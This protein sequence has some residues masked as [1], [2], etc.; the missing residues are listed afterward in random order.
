MNKSNDRKPPRPKYPSLIVFGI[1]V[2]LNLIFFQNCTPGGSL[3][4]GVTGGQT[5]GDAGSLGGSGDPLVAGPNNASPNGSGNGQGYDG[6]GLVYINLGIKPCPDQ[7]FIKSSMLV[8]SGTARLIRANCVD[9]P[10]EGTDITAETKAENPSDQVLVYQEEKFVVSK[11]DFT[12]AKHPEWNCKRSVLRVILAANFKKTTTTAQ[13]SFDLPVV[14]S[15]QIA[16]EKTDACPGT[17]TS[18]GFVNSA[19]EGYSERV[20]RFAQARPNQ[21]SIGFTGTS[22]VTISFQ[23]E[24]EDGSGENMPYDLKTRCSNSDGRRARDWVFPCVMF[25]E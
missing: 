22:D 4:P 24:F 2:V 19:R 18:I 9:L 14:S 6:K 11:G 25:E 1:V 21:V 15:S 17:N 23:H 8:Q 12:C 16:C 13:M 3:V 10:D 20:F 5:K 7:S